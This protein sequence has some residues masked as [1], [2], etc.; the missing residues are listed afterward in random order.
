MILVIDTATAACSV[1]LVDG[2]KVVDERHERVGRGHAERLVPMIEAMLAGRRPSAILVDCG[3]GSF[4]GIRVGLAAAH[5]L[6][7]GWG[8]PLAGYSSMAVVAAAAQAAG[9]IAVALE[10]GHGQLFVQTFGEEMMRPLDSLRSLPPAQAAAAISAHRVAGSGAVAL[11][12]A[13]GW[14]EALDA[15]PRAAEARSLP[16]ALR[17]LPPRPIYGR[18]PDAK[19]MP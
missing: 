8:V 7:I 15:L 13:R 11:I 4:T 19:P 10:G 12:E 18:A 1:A 9:E 14:G 3:P 2:D 6:A 16:L 17:S 5:G